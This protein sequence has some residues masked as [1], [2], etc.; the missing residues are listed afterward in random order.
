LHFFKEEKQKLK[1]N[2]LENVEKQTENKVEAE[3][4]IK[5]KNQLLFIYKGGASMKAS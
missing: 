5:M 2:K 1:I 3:Q 4:E